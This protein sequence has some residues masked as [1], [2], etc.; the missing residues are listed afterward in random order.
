M[1]LFAKMTS[2][3]LRKFL[4]DFNQSD[5]ITFFL[6]DSFVYSINNPVQEW[7]NTVKDMIAGSDSDQSI[8]VWFVILLH[9]IL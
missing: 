8:P 3:F 4:N 6:I 2:N 5:W 7:I 1:F 9:Q